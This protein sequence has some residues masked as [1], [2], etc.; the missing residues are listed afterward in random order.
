MISFRYGTK[1]SINYR[2]RFISEVSSS[3]HPDAPPDPSRQDLTEPVERAQIRN[4]WQLYRN[5]VQ[6]SLMSGSD[7]AIWKRFGSLVQRLR[8]A[9]GLGLREMSKV[10]TARMG[11]RGLSA[12][13]LSAI[14]RGLTAPPRP[15]VL[16]VLAE[17]LDVPIEK[18]KL[19]AEGYVVLDIA[20][21]LQPFPEYAELVREVR[22]GRG[23]TETIIPAMAD[24]TRR[25]PAKMTEGRLQ[26]IVK[27]GAIQYLFF[28]RPTRS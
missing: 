6:S 13:Y 2:R 28:Y 20:E 27:G 7:V 8:K 14:E 9:K 17:V 3:T 25:F 19:S 11:G 5:T 15:P 23:T 1:A 18:L 4:Y 10:A 21:T 12:A 26:I 24:A 22:E 16:A